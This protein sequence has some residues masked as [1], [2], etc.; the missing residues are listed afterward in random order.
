MRE[1]LFDNIRTYTILN[2]CHKK[3]TLYSHCVYTR[4]RDLEKRND[5]QTNG[6]KNRIMYDKNNVYVNIILLFE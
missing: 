6:E 3:Y 4:A 5:P 2:L 1:S